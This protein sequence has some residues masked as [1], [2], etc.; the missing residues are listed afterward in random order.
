MAS[1]NALTELDAY[2]ASNFSDDYWSDEG[3]LQ[4]H[5]RLQEFAVSDWTLLHGIWPSRDNTW[6]CRLANILPF[7][8]PGAALEILVAMIETAPREVLISA[9]DSM[10]E[11]D[12]GRLSA[13]QREV[14]KGWTR[15]L[16][17][18]NAAGKLESMIL[19]ELPDRL[20]G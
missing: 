12:L 18:N 6:Q 17:D 20:D 7:G 2:L 19:G 3:V 15:L 10:R 4:A 16:L 5:Q 11:M 9:L 8:E 13:D 14:I 1:P